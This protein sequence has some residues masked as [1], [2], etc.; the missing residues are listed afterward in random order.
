MADLKNND[1]NSIESLPVEQNL[2]PNK[3]PSIELDPDLKSLVF[4]TND[5]IFLCGP[6][7]TGKS[8]QL[9]LVYH[10]ALAMEMKAYICAPTGTAAVNVGGSTI[11]RLFKLGL[12]DKPADVILKIIY[13][14]TEAL[15]R[16]RSMELLLI[17]EISMLGEDILDLLDYIAKS[18]RR[19]K[20]PLGGIQLVASGDFAQLPP[21]K[22]RYCFLSSV[23]GELDFAVI[24]FTNPYRFNNK[25]HFDFLSRI[26]LGEQT[27]ED[28]QKLWKRQEAYTKAIETKQF[29]KEEIKP[30]KIYS[31]RKDVEKENNDELAKLPGKIS[32]YKAKDSFIPKKYKREAASRDS[33]S[34]KQ[35]STY[36]DTTVAQM[37]ILKPDCQVMLTSN[38]DLDNGLCNGSRGVVKECFP[39]GVQ[40]LFK[41]GQNLKILN[42]EYKYSDEKMTIKRLQLP[43][44]VAY[45]LTI[46]RIQGASLDYCIM[47]IGSSIF[48]PAMAYVSLSRVRSL[49][50]IYLISFSPRKIYADKI[51]LQ[52]EK[53]INSLLT[54]Q[55][56]SL[57]D[58]T[59]L[60]VEK[61]FERQS[62]HIRVLESV[63]EDHT[64]VKNITKLSIIEEPEIIFD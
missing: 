31:L 2:L 24:K 13:S 37:L 35:Y 58:D 49:E 11:H 29:E 46:H 5:N 23:W 54:S 50:G 61:E 6:G 25:E 17:D 62:E 8:E 48:G 60:E 19:N 18:I 32:Y 47:D 27:H 52:F 36:M 42:Q 59:I 14:H 56:F 15:E 51:A 38:L 20:K 30:T 64:I 9:K 1:L 53:A 43:L 28:I 39:D 55:E 26:R 16:I 4:T 22:D 40:I 12:A 63:E 41:N 3:K 44:I 34:E 33:E 57:D 10:H 21:V 45:S 7:G